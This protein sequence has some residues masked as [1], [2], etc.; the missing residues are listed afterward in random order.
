MRWFGHVKWSPISALL[1]VIVNGDR[2]EQ[3]W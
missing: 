3:A 2:R 1:E